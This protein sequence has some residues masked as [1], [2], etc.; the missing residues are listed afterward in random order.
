MKDLQRERGM[1]YLFIA[2]DL[3]VVRHMADRVAVMYLGKIV[4]MGVTAA[5]FRGP[6]HPY[7]QALLAAIPI[8]GARHKKTRVILKGELPSPV[9]PPSGCAFHPRCPMAEERCQIEVPELRNLGT[10]DKPHEV[11]CHLA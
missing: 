4:E 9:N 11:A 2:H 10:I 1:A 6:R 7:T 8:P 5:L 3:A